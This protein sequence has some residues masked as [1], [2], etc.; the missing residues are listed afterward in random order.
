MYIMADFYS[1]YDKKIFSKRLKEIRKLRYKQF[2]EYEQLNNN[3]DKTN[4]KYKNYKKCRS[5]ET[6]AEAINEK[7]QTI[8]NWEKGHKF[9]SLDKFI[10]L[11]NY[12]DCNA[13]YLLGSVDTPVYEPVT[14]SHYFSKIKSEIIKEGLENEHY[15]DFLNFFM[16]PENCQNIFNHVNN[17]ANNMISIKLKLDE[18][19]ESFKKELIDSF[20]EYRATYTLNGFGKES[21][22]EFLSK[23]FPYKDVINNDETRLKDYF[24]PKIYYEKFKNKS[25]AE[26]YDLFLDYLTNFYEIL[27]DNLYFEIQK[28]EFSKLFIDLVTEYARV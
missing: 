15:L 8:N 11:C 22:K 23:K 1:S 6:F 28:S 17:F 4:D 25:N 26:I 16:L 20:K 27:S 9:P 13:D 14:I 10:N 18:L 5:Q 12:L 21:F 2:Q 3:S 19:E 24:I 7:R